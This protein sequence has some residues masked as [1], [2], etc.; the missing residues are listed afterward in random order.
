MLGVTDDELR[1]LSRQRETYA[2]HFKAERAKKDSELMATIRSAKQWPINVGKDQNT[3]RSVPTQSPHR[4][5]MSPDIV[6]DINICSFN[7]GSFNN[8]SQ[9]ISRKNTAPLSVESGSVGLL[10]REK[11]KKL[12]RTQFSDEE[13]GFIDLYHRICLPSSLGFLPV[14]QRSTELDNVLWTFATDFEA[15]DWTQ[16][17]REAVEYR[18]EVFRTNPC[19]Y[20]TLVQVCWK[21]NY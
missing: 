1:A 5:N 16:K 4:N 2:L 10:E 11:P 14:T 8:G 17:F 7:N 21:L 20:N 18:R 19:K 15:D 9:N 3:T 6:P 12:D 13:L